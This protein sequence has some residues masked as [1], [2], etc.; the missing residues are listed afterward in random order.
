MPLLLLKNRVE[1][2][3]QPVLKIRESCMIQENVK[4]VDDRTFKE[5]G[6]SFFLNNQL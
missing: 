5:N 1:I 4:P 3:S 2:K 6:S